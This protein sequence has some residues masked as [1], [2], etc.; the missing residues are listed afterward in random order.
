MNSW[1]VGE[2][3]SCPYLTSS[4]S[5]SEGLVRVGESDNCLN[6]TSS[7]STSEEL[8]RV[9]ESDSCSYLTSSCSVMEF[10]PTYDLNPSPRISFTEKLVIMNV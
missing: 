4:C 8:V 5:N 6:L 3:D 2:S 9:E 1:K 10:K 7:Y